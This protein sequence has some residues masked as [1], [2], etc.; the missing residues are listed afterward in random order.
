MTAKARPFARAQPE[1]ALPVRLWLRLLGSYSAIERQ[2]RT[3]LQARFR[4]T[5]PRFDAMAQL[6]REP[7]GM[8]MGQLSDWMMVTKG[9]ITGLVD[10]LIADGL[11]ER[12]RAPND[13]RS[14][15][16]RLSKSGRARF[17]RIAPIMRRWIGEIF[18]GMPPGEMER[19]YRI[20]G[21]VRDAAERPNAKGR[22]P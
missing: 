1:E 21:R 2:L 11:A 15:I 9:N 14:S 16:V 13:G 10:R 17:D 4:T 5:M 12:T 20:L 22:A 6:R 19:L 18:A 3:R 8:T 7:D